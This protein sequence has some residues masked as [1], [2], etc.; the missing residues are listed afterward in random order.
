MIDFG[1]GAVGVEVGRLFAEY[2]AEVIKIETR[3]APDFIRVILSS[4]MNPS[5]ASSSRSK[6]SFGVNLKTERGRELVCR[7]LRDADVCIENNGTDVM[8]RLGFGPEDLKRLNPR[9]VSFQSQMVGSDGPWREWTG[10][11]PNTHPVSGLQHLWNYPEDEDSPAGS[12]NVYPDHFVAR[13]GMASV[14]AGL[15]HRERAG[16]GSHHDAAQFETAINLLGD[17]YA[18]EDLEPGSVRPLGNASSRG[19]PWGCYRCEGEDEWCVVNVRSDEEWRGLREALGDPEWTRDAALDRAEGRMK[20]RE[21]I[22][23]KLEAW[24]KRHD[25]RTVMQTL[26]A[27][28]VPAAI[29]AHPGHHLGDEQMTHRGYP[30][31]VDQQGLGSML[32]EGPAFLGSDLPP[33][34]ERQA[35]WLGEHTREIAARLLGLSDEEI[36]RLVDEDVLEDPPDEYRPIA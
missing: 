22:D 11:G 13:V 15:I 4:Y 7:L 26:Q 5:F 33:V 28:G 29:V 17:L 3:R 35:P 2:G 23:A 8:A 1:V 18:Q 31:L 12:T 32:L 19:A 10:Y 6:Q 34:I 27:A 9:I 36:Q 16:E 30:Q 20:A 25:P 21:Q 14:L 24:T